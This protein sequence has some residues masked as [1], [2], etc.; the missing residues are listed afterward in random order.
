VTLAWRNRNAPRAVVA[1]PQHDLLTKA[2]DSCCSVKRRS[3]S[4]QA[5]YGAGPSSVAYGELGLR[6][7]AR[8]SGPRSYRGLQL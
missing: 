7:S 5:Q 8:R 2:I 4:V 6:E 1:V 3:G